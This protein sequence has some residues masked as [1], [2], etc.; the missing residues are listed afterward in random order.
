[1]QKNRPSIDIE[2][3]FDY[4]SAAI[5]PKAVPA[6]VTLGTALRDRELEH[7]V[8]LL[9]GH[10][11][12]RG[13]DVYNQVLSERRAEAVRRFLAEKFEI[14]PHRLVAV[15]FGRE[16]LKIVL[17]RMAQKTG[18]FRSSICWWSETGRIRR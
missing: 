2:I 16:Q 4:N 12:A 15:G 3:Y 8:F 7:V 13:R 11:D 14:P 1:M 17:I 10:T 5:G 6:L 18:A 9:A